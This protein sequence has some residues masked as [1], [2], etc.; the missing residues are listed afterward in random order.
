LK[1]ES[2]NMFNRRGKPQRNQIAATK[3]P[4]M[5]ENEAPRDIAIK[6]AQK[7]GGK[8]EYKRRRGGEDIN[9]L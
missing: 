1:K 8:G 5:S 9:I 4:P 3:V 7:G 6:R 2:V